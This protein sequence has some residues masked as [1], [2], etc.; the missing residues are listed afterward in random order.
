MAFFAKFYTIEWEVSADIIKNIDGWDSELKIKTKTDGNTGTQ[1]N[2]GRELRKLTLPYKVLKTAGVDIREELET[3]RDI[4][5]VIAPLYV[6]RRRLLS[7]AF[8]LEDVQVS[9]IQLMPS[10]EIVSCDISLMFTEVRLSLG[11]GN[12]K[13][14][15]NGTDITSDITVVTCEHEMNA[16]DYPDTVEIKFADDNHLWDKWEPANSGD[17]VKVVNGIATTGKMY[18][19]SVIPESGYMTLTACSVPNKMRTVLKD[20]NKSWQDVMLLQVIT[21]IAGRNG[22]TLETHDVENRS[23]SFLELENVSDLEFLRERCELEGYSFVIYDDKLIVY[24]PEAIEA[25]TPSKTINMSEDSNFTY[26]DNSAKAYGSC[27]LDNGSISGSASADNGIDNS[28]RKILKGYIASQAEANTYAS[29]VLKKAN[30]GLK[31]GTFQGAIMRDLSA[32]SIATLKTSIAATNDG[33]IFYTKVRH[34]YVN[35]K[36]THFFRFV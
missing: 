31:T 10:G 4:R 22:L 27:E 19:Q 26:E 9:N 30:R 36:T 32:A 1:S 13:I 21:E 17:Y 2:G 24:S 25:E 15:Y 29:N 18:I 3:L 8:I 33:V 35:Q 6:N 14:Y 16:E 20:N 28:L 34:D 7:S 23:I 5:G 12:L 11:T